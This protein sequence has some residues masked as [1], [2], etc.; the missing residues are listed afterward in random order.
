VSDDPIEPDAVHDLAY[1]EAIPYLLVLESV[2]REG[3]W[4]RRAAYPELPNCEAEAHSALDAMEQLE[5]ERHARIRE[6]WN[7]GAPIPVPRPPLR[8]T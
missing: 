3:R 6:L 5:R 8:R 7:R 1:Y 2:E 4:V